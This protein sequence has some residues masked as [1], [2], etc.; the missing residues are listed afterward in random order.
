M[1]AEVLE[2][3]ACCVLARHTAD[4][5]DGMGAR[6]GEVETLDGGRSTCIDQLRGPVSPR[7]HSRSRHDAV[8]RDSLSQSSFGT[9]VAGQLVSVST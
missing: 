4:T 3:R 8:A 6:T 7:N 9:V 2:H 1:Q 5:G